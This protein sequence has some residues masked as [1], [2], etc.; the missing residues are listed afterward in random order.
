M[1][2]R[3]Q[4]Q[5]MPRPAKDAPTGMMEGRLLVKG[6]VILL[7]V[8]I[9]SV[10]ANAALYIAVARWFGS[11]TL[12][13][14]VSWA[15]LA[16][17]LSVIL[18]AGT[19]SRSSLAAS[20]EDAP[21]PLWE[22]A[23]WRIR[24]GMAT[25]ATLLSIAFASAA[26]DEGWPVAA[27][28]LVAVWAWLISVQTMLSGVLVALGFP[29]RG[30][31]VFVVDKVFTLAVLLLTAETHQAILAVAVAL[32][33]GALLSILPPLF[34]IRRHLLE[35]RGKEKSPRRERIDQQL[36]YLGNSLGAQFQNLDVPLVGLLAGPTQA[37]LLA[38]P[39]RLTGPIGLLASSVSSMLF[40][41]HRYLTS[42]TGS[43]SE[44][45]STWKVTGRIALGS[46]ILTTVAVSPL[47]LLPSWTMTVALGDDYR[48]SA[49]PARLVAIAMCVYAVGQPL[50]AD[51]Q[52]RNSNGH[53]TVALAV[54]SG[55]VAN[56]I[57]IATAAPALGAIAGGI[58]AIL[59]QLVILAV[60]GSF[61][62]RN[63]GIWRRN[64]PRSATLNERVGR[65]DVAE[66]DGPTTLTNPES[67]SLDAAS[68]HCK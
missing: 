22:A 43:R 67:R 45:R 41:Q 9:L 30:A 68:H 54:V 20:M 35:A 65:S 23:R 3:R 52:A 28:S 37:G 7:S 31:L 55:G 59:M 21:A 66:D 12:G 1:P 61:W 19:A 14:L 6:A 11:S 64:G 63:I 33:L 8:R 39:S 49:I 4:L 62:L 16:A 42:S 38:M 60:A 13:Q 57:V 58:G 10:V 17:A 27:I 40:A 36:S 47:L 51:L 24:T 25:S 46:A 53:R 48:D 34:L 18:D 32:P 26:R 56:G 2:Y 15:G 29:T 5:Q 44:D 50:A